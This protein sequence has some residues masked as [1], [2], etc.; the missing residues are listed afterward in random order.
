MPDMLSLTGI[1][2]VDNVAPEYDP[3]RLFHVWHMNEVYT[4]VQGTG[5]HVPRVNDLVID[6]NGGRIERYV[7]MDFNQATAV[8]VL[9]AE[10]KDLAPT[11]YE[12]NDVLLSPGYLAQSHMCYVDKS[13]RP[14]RVQVDAAYS[15]K[16][17][18]AKSYKLF[19]GVDTSANGIVVSR[20][21]DAG[22]DFVTDQ[23]PLELAAI[24]GSTNYTIKVP[25]A[26]STNYELQS[27]E[28]LT[29][30]VY[31]DNGVPLSK[32][33]LRVEE[34][35]FIHTNMQDKRYVS[36][37]SLEST[38]MSKTDPNVL[39]YPMNLPVSSMQLFGVVHYTDGSSA[40]YPVDGTKFSAL[41]LNEYVSSQIGLID[42]FDLKYQLSVDESTVAGVNAVN[43]AV[44]AHYQVK[45]MAP[46]TVL[47]VKLFVYPVWNNAARS[48]SLKWY[49]LSLSR[50][51]L[52][53]VTGLVYVT[54][55]S[56][57]P[58][59]GSVNY[60]PQVLQVGIRLSDVSP[61][62]PDYIHTQVVKIWL[63]RPGDDHTATNWVV[64]N[65]VDQA[66]YGEGIWIKAVV[67]GANAYRLDLSCGAL[68]MSDWLTRLYTNTKPLYAPNSEFAPP[69]PTHVLVTI[70]SWS[71]EF[72]VDE[73]AAIQDYTGTVD[74]NTT[75]QIV[76]Y[77]RVGAQNLILSTSIMPVWKYDA[78]GNTL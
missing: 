6:T 8:P 49:L 66:T 9:Q 19:L 20:V 42:D 51:L 71:R 41:N 65:P 48:Y 72:T 74:N 33:Y 56:S 47:G 29:C 36:H 52:A 35:S 61:T 14:Y 21:F 45:T 7:V 70:G 37:V 62:L 69:A 18:L 39:E 5:K 77:R 63:Q 64:Y 24:V 44:I 54:L 50:G 58:A 11:F 4:G 53:D 59:F 16:A 75:A 15:V 1:V 23:I 17:S 22:G 30:V 60:Q 78:L 13:V 43:N 12:P 73:Y 40:R 38:F 10:V 3:N 55:N 68:N 31:G 26:C 34:S 25:A 57:T 46:D 76:F 28:L 27:G 32:T 67:N 2:G